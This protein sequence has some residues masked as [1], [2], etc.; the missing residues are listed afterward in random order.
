MQNS[1]YRHTLT[2]KHPKNNNNSTNKNKIKRNRKRQ[3][4]WFN[5]PFNLKIKKKIDKFFLNILDKHFPPNN[6]LLKVFNWTNVKVSYNCMPSMNSYTYMCNHKVLNDKPN[7]T[8]IKNCNCRNKGTCPLPNSCQAKCM[9]YQANI[10]CAIAGYKQKCS[11]GSCETKFKDRFGNHKN[12][13]NHVKHKNDTELSKEFWEIK[14]RNRAP[15]ITYKN[16]QNMPF[17]QSKQ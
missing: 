3:I 13:F 1:G 11:F 7:E 12:S 2:Y 6:K 14:K 8:G 16:D 17:L 5:P 15:K 9:I 10:D 4:I